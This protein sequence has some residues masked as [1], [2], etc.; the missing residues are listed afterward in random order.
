[1]SSTQDTKAGEEDVE[2]V[3]YEEP[4]EDLVEDRKS[5]SSLGSGGR[6]RSVSTPVRPSTAQ[7]DKLKALKVEDI[8]DASARLFWLKYFQNKT[9]VSERTFY[10]A[11][12]ME[13]KDSVPKFVRIVSHFVISVKKRAKYDRTKFERRVDLLAFKRF[14]CRFGHERKNGWKAA[15]DC[16]KE[17]LF[18]ENKTRSGKL[19]ASLA[20]WYHADIPINKMKSIL[21]AEKNWG[22]FLVREVS[23]KDW[24]KLEVVYTKEL[25]R[26]QVGSRRK[27]VKLRPKQGIWVWVGANGKAL[28]N[29][30]LKVALK[31]MTNGRDPIQAPHSQDDY[32]VTTSSGEKMQSF[33][34][35][36]GSVTL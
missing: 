34:K 7:Q 5:P 13:F 8:P 3:P 31:A 20:P 18:E 28:G 9:D 35:V 1:M 2:G 15:L 27:I 16:V 25:G 22:K 26:G 4:E 29:K 21:L 10:E 6:S 19:L 33:Y 12:K 32:Y 23:P 36:A 11:L 17:T 30:S 24:N 14:V